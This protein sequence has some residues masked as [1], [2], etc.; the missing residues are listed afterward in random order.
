MCDTFGTVSRAAKLLVNNGVKEVI[1]CI[2]HGIFSGPAIE[3]MNNCDYIT[4]IVCS[5]SI[6]QT[7]NMKRCSKLST[8]TISNKLSDIIIKLIY[9]E[10]ISQLF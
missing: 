6:P 8:F 3:R 7:E 1:L 2:T 9:G 4:H 10:S 5:D